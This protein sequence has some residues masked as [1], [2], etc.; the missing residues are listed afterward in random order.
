MRPEI[1]TLPRAALEAMLAH[2]EDLLGA[3]EDWDRFEKLQKAFGMPPGATWLLSRLAVANG[4]ILSRQ[5]L[6]DQI[7]GTDRNRDRHPKQIDVYMVRVRA[8]L[9]GDAT[10]TVRGH[11]YRLSPLGRLRVKRAL[12]E[13]VV[14]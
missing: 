13:E 4:R 7:P 2:Y 5:A 11:G 14:F 10:E 9:G 6:L 3:S 1:A 8:A 12:G